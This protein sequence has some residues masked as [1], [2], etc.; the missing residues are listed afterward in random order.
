MAAML[1]KWEKNND[2]IASVFRRN[3]KQNPN[4]NA[5][6]IDDKKITFK[7]VRN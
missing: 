7:E 5:F 4:K 6:L 3:F 2:S 1:K